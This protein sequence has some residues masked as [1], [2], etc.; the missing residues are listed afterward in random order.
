VLYTKKIA[1]RD[2]EGKN[3]YLLGISEDI[4]RRKEIE[5]ELLN[6]KQKAEESEE[7]YRTMVSILPDGVIIH[8]NG[9]IVFANEAA[10]KIVGA[11]STADLIGLNAIDFVHPDYRVVVGS[12]IKHGIQYRNPL[13]TIEE[14]FVGFNGEPINVLVTAFPFSLRGATRYA[15]CIY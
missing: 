3:K 5:K 8:Q 11:S 6:A 12:R 1:I 4:T 10:G 13:Q 9:I 2:S 15:Y 14:V 7:R